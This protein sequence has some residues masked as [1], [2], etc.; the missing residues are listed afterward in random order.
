[1]ATGNG[2]S[3]DSS[4]PSARLCAARAVDVGG[5][6]VFG[7]QRGAGG[8]RVARCDRHDGIGGADERIRVRAQPAEQVRSLRGTAVVDGDAR[9]D[10]DRGRALC[11]VIG[12]Q[13]LVGQ[14]AGGRAVTRQRQRV[15]EPGA[16]CGRPRFRGGPI[17]LSRFDRLA[18]MMVGRV[19][20][21]GG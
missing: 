19:G 8:L 12:S 2:S 18:S 5:P 9:G 17:E 16:D 1:M 6:A 14:P 20:Q 10:P 11:R 3:S 13:E 21:R 7:A 15:G 4:S